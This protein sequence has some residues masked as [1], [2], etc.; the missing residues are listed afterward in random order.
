MP[1]V[2]PFRAIRPAPDKVHL[3]VSRSYI[4]YDHEALTHKLSSNLYSF[5]H[6]INP[7]H[8]MEDAARP[9]SKKYFKKVREKYLE[10]YGQGYFIQDERPAFYIYRQHYE[11]QGRAFTGLICATSS[12]DY[13]DGKI[14]KHELTLSK[15]EKM[16]TKYLN[17]TGINAEPVLLTYRDR[18]DVEVIMDEVK[19]DPPLYDFTT[20]D[21]VRHSLWRVDDEQNV[22]ALRNAFEEMQSFYIADGHHRC[23]SSAR[24]TEQVNG[25]TY[26]TEAPHDFFMSYLVPASQMHIEAF[27]RVLRLDAELD[28]EE[29]LEGLRDSFHVQ[30][31]DEVEIPNKH[32]ELYIYISGCHYRLTAKEIDV[33]LLDV[34]L[35]SRAILEPL[36]DITDLRNDKRIHFLSGNE[37]LDG[38]QRTLRD[39]TVDVLI[40]LYP[41]QVKE[42]FDVADRG[43]TMPPK[44]T[45]V[46]P[47]L[48]S[49]LTI[50]SLKKH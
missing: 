9:G 28:R 38:V 5:I 29:V 30:P 3:V 20:T 14:K 46:E 48:R 25:G 4:S 39:E 11:N 17:I 24:L 23:A 27:H 35:C 43:E 45:W 13:V 36:F 40:A 22:I 34:E 41:T 26:G 15:R 42:I 1:L 18:K 19:K 50:Y 37:G 33:E 7:D 32:G 10:F 6:V 2:R 21:M 8:G 31:L 12:Q 47:K 49:A 44:S 16:F